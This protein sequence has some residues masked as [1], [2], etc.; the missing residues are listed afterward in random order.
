VSLDEVF[1]TNTGYVVVPEECMAD[2]FSYALVF[3]MEGPEGSSYPYPEIIEGI[4]AHL[5]CQVSCFVRRG[6]LSHTCVRRTARVP[7][8][9]G[10]RAVASCGAV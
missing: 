1:G 10:T 5:T 3:G 6:R 8:A 4:I 9:C 2:Y 7:R